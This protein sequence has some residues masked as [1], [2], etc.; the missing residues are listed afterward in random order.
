MLLFSR[1]SE[2]LAVAAPTNALTCALFREAELSCLQCTERQRC[3]CWLDGSLPNDD[4]HE[5]C[6]NA[7]LIAVLPRQ[8]NL[9]V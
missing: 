9:D 2:R 7:G 3:E 5:F 1:M 8:E 6:P 4:Y